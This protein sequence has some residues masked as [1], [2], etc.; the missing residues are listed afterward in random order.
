MA[1]S[2]IGRAMYYLAQNK[3]L[4]TALKWITQASDADPKNSAG[5]G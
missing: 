1:R 4:P 2:S 3:D 5:C